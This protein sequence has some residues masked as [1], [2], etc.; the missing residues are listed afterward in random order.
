L[1]VSLDSSRLLG[2]GVDRVVY[3]WHIAG[4]ELMGRV[5]IP[6]E[7]GDHLLGP[8]KDVALSADRTLLAALTDTQILILNVAGGS[9]RYALPLETPTRF[10]AVAF[11]PSGYWLAASTQQG[12]VFLW[13]ASD[14]KLQ[15]TFQAGSRAPLSGLAFSPDSRLLMAEGGGIVLW[16]VANGEIVARQADSGQGNVGDC[17]FSPDS[18]LIAG[19]E[20]IPGVQTIVH[21]WRADSGEE[22]YSLSLPVVERVMF[23]P[24]GTLLLAQGEDGV[25]FVWGVARP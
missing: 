5:P 9:L 12:E 20:S 7:V 13:K 8:V 24:D 19:V 16:R 6:D 11:S 1:I 14:G 17:A 10:E 3:L 2:L 15:R 22:V 21:L 23:S 25:I 18:R 4:G